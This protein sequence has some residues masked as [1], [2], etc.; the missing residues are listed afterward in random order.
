MQNINAH[1]GSILDGRT[2]RHAG[3]RLGQVVR[4]WIEDVNSWI[5]EVGGMAQIKRQ[6]TT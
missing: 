4:N 6:L 5:K 3:Y 2:T 1:R